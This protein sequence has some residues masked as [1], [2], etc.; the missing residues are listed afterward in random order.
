MR[1]IVIRQRLT[2]TRGQDSIV[3]IMKEC[4]GD[5]LVRAELRNGEFVVVTPELKPG[6]DSEG[7]IVD[8][9]PPP[10]MPQILT[11]ATPK[12]EGAVEGG[13]VKVDVLPS[14]EELKGRILLKVGNITCAESRCWTISA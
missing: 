8:G 6:V 11:T 4:F 9:E 13:V 14:P 7:K 1:Y 2:S 5:T 10:T 12:V 3:R